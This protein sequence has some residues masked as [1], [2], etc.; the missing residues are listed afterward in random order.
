MD[1]DLF[2]KIV[3]YLA[4]TGTTVSFLPQAIKCIMSKD[5]R[6]ISL[7]MYILFVFGTA[8]WAAYG[9]YNKDW[10]IIVANVI[11]FILAG[12]ILVLKICN[13]KKEKAD[14]SSSL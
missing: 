5:T 10:P 14:K 6:N 9:I 3:G 1:W 8:C 7:W 13:L 2:F 11:T 4:A 12:I